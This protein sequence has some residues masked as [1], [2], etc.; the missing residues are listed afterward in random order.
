MVRNSLLLTNFSWS[1]HSYGVT[2]QFEKLGLEQC[3][4]IFFQLRMLVSCC[5]HPHPFIYVISICRPLGI[6]RVW[7]LVEKCW[8][9]SSLFTQR[10]GMFLVHIP[11]LGASSACGGPFFQGRRHWKLNANKSCFLNRNFPTFD[12][13]WFGQLKGYVLVRFGISQILAFFLYLES[14]FRVSH[15]QCKCSIIEPHFWPI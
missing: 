11:F 8:S 13:C 12:S 15:M 10:C 3:F 7:P 6:P 5:A 9:K 14:N 1:P 2:A 4:S